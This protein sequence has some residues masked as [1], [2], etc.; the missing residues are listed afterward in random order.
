MYKFSVS[1]SSYLKRLLLAAGAAVIITFLLGVLVMWM[2]GF[3]VEDEPSTAALTPCVF[4]EQRNEPMANPFA[5]KPLVLDCIAPED[6]K[7]LFVQW[8]D[9]ILPRRAPGQGDSESTGR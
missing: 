3:I 4:G 6:T 7:P 8:F 5:K 1:K 2:N 9:R